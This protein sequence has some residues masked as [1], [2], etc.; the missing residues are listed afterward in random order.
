MMQN[1]F[2]FLSNLTAVVRLL[3]VSLIQSAPYPKLQSHSHYGI[4]YLDISVNLPRRVT[5]V[6]SEIVLVIKGTAQWKRRTWNTLLVH[7]L[8]IIHVNL[9]FLPV[10]LSRALAS[11]VSICSRHRSVLIFPWKFWRAEEPVEMYGKVSI[12]NYSDYKFLD[13]PV[14]PFR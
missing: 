14:E 9:S 8:V 10:R 3:L 6:N 1:W 4:S 13:L 2:W 7:F 11:R 5:F 12:N